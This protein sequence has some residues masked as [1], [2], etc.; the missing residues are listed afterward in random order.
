[1]NEERKFKDI[2]ETELI[3]TISETLYYYLICNVVDEEDKKY[4]EENLTIM[5]ERWAER[6]A[7]CKR[8]RNAIEKR[9]EAEDSYDD[10]E[11]VLFQEV[12]EETQ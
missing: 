10:F 4:A 12:E 6:D 9:I 7:C 3:K 2:G 1:M 8:I 5:R 11:D